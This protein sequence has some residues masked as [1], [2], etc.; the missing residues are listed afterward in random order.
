MND[1]QAFELTIIYDEAS[2]RSA[3][4][5]LFWRHW[6]SKWRMNAVTLVA[7]LCAAG[8]F[9][10]LGFFSWIWWVGVSLIVMFA[11]WVYIR[12]ATER[13]V[14][15]LLGKTVKMRL[16]E[17]DFT[18]RSEGDSHTFVWKRFNS[19]QLDSENLYMFLG[20]TL[21]YMLPLRQASEGA[22]DFAKAHIGVSSDPA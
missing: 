15:K 17:D 16:A 14:L 4:A 13:R 3:A 20:R 6:K 11:L 2:L 12:W 19:Y 21:A 7:M 18:I 9:I 1:A 10:Y 22:I 8:M 5:L